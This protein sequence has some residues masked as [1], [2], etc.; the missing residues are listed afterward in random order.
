ME[1]GYIPMAPSSKVTSK[2]IYLKD[3]ENGASKMVI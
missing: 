3:K 1:N 2:I